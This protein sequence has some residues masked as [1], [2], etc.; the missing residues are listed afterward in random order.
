MQQL[1]LIGFP[2]GHSFSAKYFKEKF[3]REHLSEW[4][5]Q[6]YPLATISE[7]APLLQTEN[8][9]GLNVTIPYK[10]AVLAYCEQIDAKAAAV[11]A[12]NTLV[13]TKEGWKGY[14]TDI[15]G[16]EN[17]L[18]PL[19]RPHHQQALIFGT[20]G[21]AK[22]VAYVLRQIGVH[23]QFVSRK[24]GPQVISYSELLFNDLRSHKLWINTT[25]VGQAPNAEEVLPIDFSQIGEQHLL[26]DLIYNPSLTSFLKQGQL[27]GATILN[28][29][30]MLVEQAEAA[31]KIWQTAI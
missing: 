6:N 31:F 1:G 27:K 25:P 14:N 18:L 30:Q 26:F 10:E 11:W 3:E 4:N 12:V 24:P 28:G 17:S 16:I 29:E 8:L 20:G 2:L 9:K 5:Y 23:F 19:V 22:A 13:K 21:A 7:L 15:I